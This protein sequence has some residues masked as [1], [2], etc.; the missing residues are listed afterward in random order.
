MTRQNSSSF[1]CIDLFAGCGGL[2]LGLHEAG[3]NGV[4]AIERD[5]MAFETLNNNLLREGAS[6]RA[7]DVWPAWLPKTNHDIVSLL[8]D[9]TFRK[10][11]A[12]LRGEVALMAGGPPC[13]G[14]SVGGKRDGADERN[15]LVF[16]MLDMVDLVRPRV[17]LIE[18]VE[19]I[20]RRFVARPGEEKSSVADAVIERLADLGYTGTFQ[21]LDASTFGVPQARKRV[22]IIGVADCPVD[23]RELKSMFVDA[24]ARAAVNVRQNWGLHPTNDVSAEEAIHDLHGGLRVVCPDSEKFDSAKYVKAESAYAKAMRRGARTGTVPNS[25]RFSKHGAR[26]EELYQLAHDTQ[27]PGRL[28]KQ[29]LLANDTKKDKKVLIDRDKVVSTITTHPDEFIHYAEPRNITVREM[30]RMQSFPDDFH[31]FGRYTINGPR[32]KLDVARCSQ[33]GN[34]VPPLLAEGLGRAIQEILSR[35]DSKDVN[36]T[37]AIARKSNASVAATSCAG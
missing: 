37:P 24:I 5:P 6:H 16:Q 19:G 13:Q 11:V 21:V 32:R 3:W 25:H 7:Y 27:P 1:S 36:T 26:I 10:N 14:F 2:S 4:F 8:K 23:A 17:V 34:A 12:S 18:N 35:M 33:V 28:S 20:A 29:F 31:F 30:A 22:A 15:T 9:P